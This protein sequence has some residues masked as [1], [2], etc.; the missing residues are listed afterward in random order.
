MNLAEFPIAL[1]SSR[2]NR[3]TKTL[4]FEDQVWDKRAGDTITRRLTVSASDKYGLPTALDDEVIVGLIQLTRENGFED[5][6]VFFSRYEL[7]RLLGWRNEGKSY[8]RLDTSM[9]RWLG[10]TLYYENAWWDKAAGAWVDEHFH[11]LD[12]V[13]VYDRRRRLLRCGMDELPLSMFVW[14]DVVFRSFQSGYLKRLDMELYRGLESPI[15]KRL[16]R[17]LDKRFYH[18]RAWTF[19]LRTF[20]CEHVGL[21]RSYDAAGLKRKLR[22]AIGELVDAGYLKATEVERQFEQV[23]RGRWNVHFR[24]MSTRRAA[25]ESEMTAE[26]AELINRGVNRATARELAGKYDSA[27]IRRH[28]GAVD[29]IAKEHPGRIR[30]V[31]GFLVESIRHGY[32]HARAEEG[33]RP[34]ANTRGRRSQCQRLDADARIGRYLDGLSTEKRRQLE[35]RAFAS[36]DPALAASHTRVRREGADLLVDLY[37]R[38]IMHDYVKR[39]RKAAVGS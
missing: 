36:A 29:R 7:I 3:N 39:T 25:L 37:R 26:V 35:K 31:P 22:P 20:C 19:D 8:T 21:S 12:Q 14:N 23:G 24:R 2:P 15:A 28:I 27:S 16:Y 33:R 17:V 32:D 4:Q 9:R 6:Q 10:V 34:S 1:L 13:L 11:M 38:L 30:S 18:K 5:R